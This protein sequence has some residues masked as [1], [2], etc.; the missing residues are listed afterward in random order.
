[1]KIKRL[2][3]SQRMR[4]IINGVAIFTTAKQIRAGMFGYITQMEAS[5]QALKT[6]E[7]TRSGP[8]VADQCANG[9]CGTWAGHQVQLDMI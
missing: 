1:M 8:G 2:K 7:S 3:Q 5:M 4:I 6:L 9:L